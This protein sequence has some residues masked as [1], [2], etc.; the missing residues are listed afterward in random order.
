MSDLTTNQCYARL[1]NALYGCIHSALLF[2]KKLLRDLKDRGFVV[3]PYDPCVAKKT[4]NGK[5]FTITWHVDDLKLSHVDVKVVDEM[6]S[7]LKSIYGE[8]M[9]ILWG[10]K[11]Y[12][13]GMYLDYLVP[14]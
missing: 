5:Q 10:K 11:H 13:L 14:G 6:I 1:Q 12:Y 9:R 4:I 7:W 2:Y 3:N 8:D